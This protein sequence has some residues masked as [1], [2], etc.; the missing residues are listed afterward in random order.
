MR[1]GNEE[2]QT[3]D[4]NNLIRIEINKESRNNDDNN[5]IRTKNNEEARNNDKQ[6][7]NESWKC[8]KM[9]KDETSNHSFEK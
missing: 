2:S 8:F 7:H 4:N 9:F 1:T 6:K 5:I 3:N